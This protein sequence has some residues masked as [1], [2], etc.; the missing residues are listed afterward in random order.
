MNFIKIIKLLNLIK[1]PKLTKLVKAIKLGKPIKLTKQGLTRLV[2]KP[3]LSA[4]FKLVLI[5]LILSIKKL[6]IEKQIFRYCPQAWLG[7]NVVMLK[8]YFCREITMF[9]INYHNP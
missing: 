4:V 1:L 5:G 8:L 3:A 7:E 2:S 9:F 6:N